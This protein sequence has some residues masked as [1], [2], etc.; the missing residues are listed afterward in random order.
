M[1]I[2]NTTF[3]LD[4]DIHDEGLIFLKETYVLAAVNSGFLFEPRL[5]LIHRQH[6]ESGHSYSLQFKVKN[7]DTLNLWQSIQGQHLNNKMNEQFRNK[8]VGFTT[9]LEEIE[10]DD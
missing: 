2:F 7:I 1:I 5:C 3:H 8:M 4:D 9:I 6:E 10:L